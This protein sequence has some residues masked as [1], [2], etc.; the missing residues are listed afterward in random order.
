MGRVVPR[1][2][3]PKGADGTARPGEFIGGLVSGP[4]AHYEPY[5][6][7]HIG[8]P[9]HYEFADRGCPFGTAPSCLCILYS[10]TV[11]SLFLELRPSQVLVP[12]RPPRSATSGWRG[13]CRAHR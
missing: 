8:R 10:V 12:L 6:G 13:R 4:V 9:L 11:E 1:R 2:R 3:Y 7:R 5:S